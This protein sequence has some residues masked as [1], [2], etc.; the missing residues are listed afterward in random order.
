MP[1]AAGKAV[2]VV[3][4]DHP[5]IAA[6]PAGFDDRAGGGCVDRISAVAA[7][8]NAGVHGRA[9]DE[10]IGAHPERRY[11]DA[12]EAAEQ[13]ADTG[14]PGAEIA[15]LM[16]VVRGAWKSPPSQTDW[17]RLYLARLSLDEHPQWSNAALSRALIQTATCSESMAGA[18]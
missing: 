1:V 7:K 4:F 6:A 9:S 15:E 11:W 8:I 5:T 17:D 18:G 12:I 2:A 14:K 13:W 3:D 16:Q 10:G